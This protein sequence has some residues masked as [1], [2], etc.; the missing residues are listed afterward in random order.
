MP[1]DLELQRGEDGF[2][3]IV[4]AMP[5]RAKIKGTLLYDASATATAATTDGTL[6]A[7]NIQNGGDVSANANA[8]K[9]SVPSV[10]STISQ[11]E[12]KV[13]KTP[14]TQ[15][16]SSGIY[17]DR[18]AKEYEVTGLSSKKIFLDS[19]VIDYDGK[20]VLVSNHALDM[21][22]DTVRGKRF[23]HP[24]TNSVNY[25]VDKVDSLIRGL[26]RA[27]R[28][29]VERVDAVLSHIREKDIEVVP[30]RRSDGKYIYVRAD[31]VKYFDKMYHNTDKTALRLMTFTSN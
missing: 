12:E 20:K 16:T 30:F 25:T 9:E 21:N 2:Y 3:S 22:F 8:N 24:G 28:K 17:G 23:V 26:K 14:Q 27:H 18:I 4:S 10:D 13:K 19:Q 11:K 6:L 1:L 29:N 7:N 31:Y 5:H 15:K